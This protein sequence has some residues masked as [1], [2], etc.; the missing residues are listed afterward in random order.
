MLVPPLPGRIVDA[1]LKSVF[2]SSPQISGSFD[3]Q[4]G[5]IAFFPEKKIRI[6]LQNPPALQAT[7][8]QDL[9]Q[10]NVAPFCLTLYS[11][12]LLDIFYITCCTLQLSDQP[13]L[14]FYVFLKL[15]CKYFH[16]CR[17]KEITWW[18]HITTTTRIV[19]FFVLLEQIEAF[20]NFIFNRNGT[21]LR[22]TVCKYRPKSTFCGTSSKFGFRSFLAHR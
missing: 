6:A 12:Q 19:Q 10:C 14:Q 17:N 3:V 4:D 5:G 18:R 9:H 21:N 15:L 20:L 11:Q 16:F 13:C 7:L 1:L 22:A 8:P 2:D